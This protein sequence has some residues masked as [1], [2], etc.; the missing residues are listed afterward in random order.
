[1]SLGGGK[2]PEELGPMPGD[3]IVVQ[4]A[5]QLELIRKATLVI[6]HAGLNTTL[7][8]LASGVPMVAIPVTNDQP[9]VAARIEWFGAGKRIPIAKLSVAKLNQAVREVLGN[10]AYRARAKELQSRITA[11]DG[12]ETAA[13]IVERAFQLGAKS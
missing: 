8:S 2:K 6:T 1:L 3:P 7:E 13:S 5:P 9:G 11:A 12:L 4:Y 10:P